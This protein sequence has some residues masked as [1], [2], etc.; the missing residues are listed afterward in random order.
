MKALL[1]GLRQYAD[2]S[3]TTARK[4]FWAFISVTQVT[5]VILLLPAWLLFVQLFDELI[6]HPRILDALFYICQTADIAWDY[7]FQELSEAAAEVWEPFAESLLQDHPFS[8]ICTALAALWGLILIIPTLA[9]TARRLRDSG[10]C[11]WWLLPLIMMLIPLPG[12]A[13]L[14][15]IGSIITLIFCCQPSISDKDSPLPPVPGS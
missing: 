14:G 2:F 12:V 13:D 7:V 9:I 6:N 3:G 11:R 5:L 4:E 1:A 8:L 10:H 15:F